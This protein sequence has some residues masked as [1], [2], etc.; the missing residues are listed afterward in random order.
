MPLKRSV[1]FLDWADAAD[2]WIIEDDYVSEFRYSGAPIP[3]LM[4]LATSNR[5]DS[6]RVIY[7]GSFSK[8]FSNELRLGF[9][10]LPERLVDGAAAALFAEGA[11]ASLMPQRALARFM[12]E[13][14]FHK[15]IRRVRR[16]YGERR[17]ALI[18]ALGPQ[19]AESI[20][21]S[22]HKAGMHLALLLDAAVERDALAQAL[23]Q[24]LAPRSLSA[25]AEGTGVA[26]LR[27]GF[28]AHTPEEI[29][30]HGAV[31]RRC[32]EGALASV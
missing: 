28:C 16:V 4:G 27:I 3:A 9:L 30:A 32:T 24:G 23:G 20:V 8:V 13:G 25:C 6:G 19:L 7:S 22:A 29:A 15:H 17:V 12:L 26:G 5:A 1:E 21:N 31:L 11:K 10:V 18:D 2:A 14:H